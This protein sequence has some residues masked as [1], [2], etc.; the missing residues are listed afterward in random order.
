MFIL[1]P[2]FIRQLRVC[3]MISLGVFFHF[4][5]ILIFWANNGVKEQKWPKIGK[6]LNRTLSEE[7]YVI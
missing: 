4:L 5:K 7:E 1:T 3:K 2:V 6:K